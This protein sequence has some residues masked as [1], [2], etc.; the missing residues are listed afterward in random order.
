MR[1]YTRPDVI[2]DHSNQ[3][4]KS[5]SKELIKYEHVYDKILIFAE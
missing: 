2:G 5:N 4:L 1:A 3:F